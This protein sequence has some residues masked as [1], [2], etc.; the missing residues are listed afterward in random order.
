[1]IFSVATNQTNKRA[2]DVRRTN[3]TV[4]NLQLEHLMKKYQ[5]KFDDILLQSLNSITEIYKFSGLLG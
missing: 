4:H 5:N 3:G 1:M 2:Y